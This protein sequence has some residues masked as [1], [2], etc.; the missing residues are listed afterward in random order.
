MQKDIKLPIGVQRASPS[1][2][3][4]ANA[5]TNIINANATNANAKHQINVQ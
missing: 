4:T 1:W 3:T 2:R 5:R